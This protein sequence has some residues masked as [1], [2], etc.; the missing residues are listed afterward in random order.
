MCGREGRAVPPWSDSGLTDTLVVL[1]HAA[2]LEVAWACQRRSNSGRAQ[3]AKVAG[4]RSIS[5]RPLSGRYLSFSEREEIAI[6]QCQAG[7][8]A[9]DRSP[10]GPVGLDDLEGAAP[11]R[12][13]A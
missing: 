13:D 4:C 3:V 2:W 11:Q 12:V 10:A 9:R 1:V 6:L 8:C 5:M 7:G